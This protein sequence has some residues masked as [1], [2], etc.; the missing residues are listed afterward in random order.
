MIFMMKMV[1]L[2]K[3]LE[4]TILSLTPSQIIVGNI[5]FRRDL[6]VFHKINEDIMSTNLYIHNL[7]KSI[8]DVT[9]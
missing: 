6:P 4:S 3:T 8:K 5:P 9:F 2:L 7:S 1:T